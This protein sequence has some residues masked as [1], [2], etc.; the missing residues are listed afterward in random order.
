MMML[1]AR[2]SLL[3]T[4]PSWSLSLSFNKKDFFKSQK[5]EGIWLVLGKLSEGMSVSTTLPTFVLDKIYLKLLAFLTQFHSGLNYLSK[6]K[7]GLRKSSQTG[8]S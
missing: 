3:C 8:Y 1:K 4:M 2:R 6:S 5:G 7:Q